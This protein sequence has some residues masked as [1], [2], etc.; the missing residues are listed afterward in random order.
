MAK[1]GTRYDDA[2]RAAAVAL[3]IEQKLPISRAAKQLGVAIETLR[4]W[5]EDSG[6][7]RTD[8]SEKTDKQRIRELEREL[9]AARMER[10]ILK[11]AVRSGPPS[12]NARN[13]IPIHRRSPGEMASSGNGARTRCFQTGLSNMEATRAVEQSNSLADTR[14]THVR[15]QYVRNT[16]DG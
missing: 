12:V 15:G 13:E 7:K 10:D 8:E 6:R 1:H 16:Q 5:V 2:Y 3:V 14:R 11:E 9:T 4:K